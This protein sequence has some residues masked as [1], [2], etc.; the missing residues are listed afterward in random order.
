[1]CGDALDD[2]MQ[3]GQ[4]RCSM[5]GLMVRDSPQRVNFSVIPSG[6]H[7]LPMSPPLFICA[8]PALT[9]P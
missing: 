3:N 6:V 4:A 5:Y 1:M 9:V 2:V 7:S 8:F